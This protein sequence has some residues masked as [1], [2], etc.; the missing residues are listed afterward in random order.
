[1]RASWKPI[2]LALL[3]WFGLAESSEQPESVSLSPCLAVDDDRDRL[4]CYDRVAGRVTSPQAKVSESV[5][6]TSSLVG[7]PEIADPVAEFGMTESMQRQQARS[8]SRDD[9]PEQ[10]TA[11]VSEIGQTAEGRFVVT[12]NNGQEWVQSE[13]EPRAIVRVGEQVTVKRASFG[14]YLLTTARNIPTRVRR[15]R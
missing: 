8:P 14:S 4:D 6:T 11:T 7:R 2:A 13:T 10:I 3:G 12:L 1:M 15:I 9:A 5:A